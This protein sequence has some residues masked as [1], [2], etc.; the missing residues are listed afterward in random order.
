MHKRTLCS[1]FTLLELCVAL[2]LFSILFLACVRV[3]SMIFLTLQDEKKL[4][5]E[6]EHLT[7]IREGQRSCPH[8]IFHQNAWYCIAPLHDKNIAVP[9]DFSL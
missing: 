7:M 6:Y 9:V 2:A 4:L 8:V 3:H 5:L 1:G